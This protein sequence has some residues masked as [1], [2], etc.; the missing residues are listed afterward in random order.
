[1][2]RKSSQELYR[3]QE[4][5]LNGKSEFDAS[6]NSYIS[7]CKTALTSINSVF[8]DCI[9]SEDSN[10]RACIGSGGVIFKSKTKI[11][12]LI[13]DVTSKLATFDKQVQAEAD[14]LGQLAAKAAAE[15]AAELAAKAAARAL[16]TKQ[17]T[18][19]TTSSLVSRKLDRVA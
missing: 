13:S 12:N 16:A 10:L 3:E 6:V 7:Q 11:I 15:E 1:M 9:N 17:T 18:T 8:D 4:E 14:R 2:I 5:L 19:T